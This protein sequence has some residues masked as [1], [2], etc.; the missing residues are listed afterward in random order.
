MHVNIKHLVMFTV[1]YIDRGQ[2]P[3]LFTRHQLEQSLADHQAVQQKVQAY[4]V[5]FFFA[6]SCRYDNMYVQ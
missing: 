6:F 5:C 2:N 1:R 4:K 3:D